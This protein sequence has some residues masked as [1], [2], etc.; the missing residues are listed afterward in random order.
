M[1]WNIG[2]PVLQTGQSSA[3]FKAKFLSFV[4]AIVNFKAWQFFRKVCFWDLCWQNLYKIR[5]NTH[6][7]S[8]ILINFNPDWLSGAPFI[9]M[10]EL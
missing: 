1:Y 5:Y 4:I 3:G 8:E 7:S 9:D 6:F 2:K 10:H